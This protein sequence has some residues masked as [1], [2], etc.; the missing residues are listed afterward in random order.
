MFFKYRKRAEESFPRREPFL[1]RVE[2]KEFSCHTVFIFERD[3]VVTEKWLLT[4]GH[5]HRLVK[6]VECVFVLCGDF[7]FVLWICWVFSGKKGVQGFVSRISGAMSRRKQA[8]PRAVLKR[9]QRLLAGCRWGEGRR[10]RRKES[11]KT[12]NKNKRTQKTHRWN[13]LRDLLTL[14][15]IPFS[16]Y[17]R[18]SVV[19]LYFFLVLYLWIQYIDR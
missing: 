1:I 9:K 3:N 19:V 7:L 6:P 12:R 11:S 15:G 17:F 4:K 5:N 2:F 10:R 16:Y 18:F 14:W 13:F 8:K